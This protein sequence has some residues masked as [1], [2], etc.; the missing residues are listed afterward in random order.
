M[1][2][3]SAGFVV[4]RTDRITSIAVADEPPPMIPR[5]HPIMN[6]LASILLLAFFIATAGG[7]GFVAYLLMR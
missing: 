2:R 4:Y 6:A 7:L 3:H 1:T 5:G